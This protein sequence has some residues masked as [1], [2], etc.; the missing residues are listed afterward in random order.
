M[1]CQ[2]GELNCGLHA[3]TICV[4]I[5]APRCSVV[6]KMPESRVNSREHRPACG[7]VKIGKVVIC[8]VCSH[9]IRLEYSLRQ[10][11]VI[12]AADE[13]GEGI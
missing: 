1:A 7:A 10:I 11:N 6:Q 3:T 4:V 13:V 12:R 9:F 5:E 8:E 2:R